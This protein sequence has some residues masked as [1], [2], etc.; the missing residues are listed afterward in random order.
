MKSII[1]AGGSGTRLFPMSRNKYP[2]QFIRFGSDETFFQKTARRILKV[3]SE[4]SD[5]III[6]NADYQF[7]VKIS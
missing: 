2:K 1:L 4:L 5:L 7:Y 3:V 6:A